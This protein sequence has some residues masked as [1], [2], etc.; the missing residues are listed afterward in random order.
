VKHLLLAPAAAAVLFWAAPGHATLLLAAEVGGVTFNCA[1]QSGCDT[2]PTVG[3]LAVGNQVLGGVQFLGSVQ[4]QTIG[5]VNILNTSSLTITNTNATAVDIA[6][7]VSG[8]DF[9]GPVE[10]FSASG[11]G[12]WQQAIG[13]DLTLG[14][15]ND[16]NNQ[17][18]AETVNDHPGVL[19]HSFS[20]TATLITD[21][22]STVASGAV[23]DPNLFSMTET[24]FGTLTA[25]GSLVNRGQTE[26]KEQVIPEPAS[27]AILGSGL[28]MLGWA[29]R[30]R[31]QG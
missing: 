19:L 12:T 16:A 20:D 15:Y 13:S 7:A 10:S 29:V 26:I 18:G 28:M 1:D 9:T 22:F 14:W 3:I 23:F 24:A 2:N 25:G 6:F 8:T 11:S 17:Q 5:S 4:E 27:L 21:A 30:R 31:R